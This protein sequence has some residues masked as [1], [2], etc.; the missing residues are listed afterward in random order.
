MKGLSGQMADHNRTSEQ[1]IEDLERKISQYNTTEN[2]AFM[3]TEVN[4]AVGSLAHL[5]GIS[6]EALRSVVMPEFHFGG[7]QDV[8]SEK[9]NCITMAP[10]VQL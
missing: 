3:Q 5:F 4:A 1:I 9:D 6:A 8:Y 2:R 10:R 7:W